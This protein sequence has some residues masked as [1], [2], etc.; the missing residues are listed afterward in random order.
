M[1]ITLDETQMWSP[2]G[3]AILS[4]LFPHISVLAVLRCS[5]SVSGWVPLFL[6]CFKGTEAFTVHV[7]YF[8][9]QNTAIADG[10]FILHTSTSDHAGSFKELEWFQGVSAVLTGVWVACCEY[11]LVLPRCRMKPL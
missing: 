9:Q 11:S 2:C 6:L 5:V 8:F 4:P 10:E 7:I 3:S 1:W